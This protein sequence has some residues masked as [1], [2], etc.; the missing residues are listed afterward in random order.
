MRIPEDVTREKFEIIRK[1][2]EKGEIKVQQLKPF[3]CSVPS[4]F[5]AHGITPRIVQPVIGLLQQ[6]NVKWAE[7]GPIETKSRSWLTMH[8]HDAEQRRNSVADSL[9]AEGWTISCYS[10]EIDPK[11]GF[12]SYGLEAW[13][14]L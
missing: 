13:R 10:V 8:Y 14:K 12:H 5:I 6:K 3:A 1:A 4:Y 9:T 7:V 2:Y 11:L